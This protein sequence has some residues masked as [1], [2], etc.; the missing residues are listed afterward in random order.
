M[1]KFAWGCGGL[2][3][4]L[5]LVAIAVGIGGCGTYN[6]IV[7]KQ[8]QTES[9][10]AQVENQYK[11]R[12]DLIPSLVETVKGAANFERSTLTEVVEARAAATQVRIDP[13]NVTP[14]QLKQFEDTQGRLS[15]ALSR[16][17]VSVERYPELRANANFQT[18]Q[19]QI[20]GTE[21]RIAVERQKFND[22]V[23]T[24]NTA[25]RQFPGSFVAG[26]G[27]FTPKPYF[28]APAGSDAPP[29]VKFDFGKGTN[30]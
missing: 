23:R 1:K 21:N 6:G 19:A 25:I 12:A 28:Q 16:L 22:A 4:V 29:S 24:Y 2:V 18:L 5:L 14:E 7:A 20:E 9:A 8:Q 13:A 10:W 27:H 11:R 17:L 3:A 15:S 30:K 26:F